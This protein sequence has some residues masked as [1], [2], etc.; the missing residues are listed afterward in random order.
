M[1]FRV[2][3]ALLGG[4]TMKTL[5]GAAPEALAGFSI[6]LQ[7]GYARHLIISGAVFF[8]VGCAGYLGA[9]ALMRGYP[10]GVLWAR[11]AMGALALFGFF[12][13]AA[14]GIWLVR[15]SVSS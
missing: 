11:R 13:L 8:G 4:E 9:P 12:L 5:T 7:A 14:G 3:T 1:W 10:D 2:I 6:F 15:A